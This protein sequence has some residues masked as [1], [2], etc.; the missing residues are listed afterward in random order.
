MNRNLRITYKAV[1]LA[2]LIFVLVSFI[3]ASM[4][5]DRRPKTGLF[6]DGITLKFDW[7]V[8]VLIVL[9]Y[10]GFTV[11]I[12][13]QLLL[14]FAPQ[15]AAAALQ[16]KAIIWLVFIIELLAAGFIGYL[17]ADKIQ[18]YFFPRP[19]TILDSLFSPLFPTNESTLV[20]G[21]WQAVNYSLLALC[22]IFFVLFIWKF[23]KYYLFA[24]N[25][26]IEE[27]QAEP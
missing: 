4:Y 6:P 9:I 12:L 3:L 21:K 27:A 23:R 8:D 24:S 16:R 2:R 20:I 19:R 1:A 18:H 5:A 25:T 17:A 26:N 7:W 15:F 11:V 13:F 14:S 10:C 22:S